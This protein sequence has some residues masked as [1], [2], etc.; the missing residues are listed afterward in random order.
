MTGQTGV[1]NVTWT[2]TKGACSDNATTTINPIDVTTTL[3]TTNP[4]CTN[5]PVTI[6]GSPVGVGSFWSIMSSPATI[7]NS[8]AAT[9]TV[10]GL[11][12]G[13]NFFV[14]NAVVG[15]HTCTSTLLIT[16]NLAAPTATA[17]LTE[18]CT[19]F[20]HLDGSSPDPGTGVWSISQG[21]RYIFCF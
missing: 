8:L 11:G 14:W 9:T 6:T 12:F 18:A 13:D 21:E 15:G 19:D 1:Y 4:V 2:I 3:G 10:N 17:S 20:V 5:G 7:T 16:N